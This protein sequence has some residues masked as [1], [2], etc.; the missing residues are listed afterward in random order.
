MKNNNLKPAGTPAWFPVA[1]F[2]I[3]LVVM[4]WRSFLPDYVFFNNDGPL[5]VQNAAWVKMPAGVTGMWVDL[6]YLGNSGGAYT[7]SLTAMFHSLFSPLFYAKFFQM[8]DLF[9]VALGTWMLF[10]AL[11][12]SPLASTLGALAAMLNSTYFSTA[13]WGVGT[14]EIA[15]GMNSFALALIVGC[16]SSTPIVVRWV[17][18]MLAGMCVGVNVM[19]ASDIGALYSLLVALF[20]FVHALADGEGA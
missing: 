7:P 12:L 3:V 14:Q 13:C 8:F 19:E 10:R 20:V 2:A 15:V 18:L 4:F 5:G 17:R 6:N 16:S 9:I 11:K 1:L